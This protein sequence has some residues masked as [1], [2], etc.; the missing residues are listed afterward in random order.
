MLLKYK[1]MGMYT[2]FIIDVKLKENTPIEIIECIYD[3]V[4]DK[5]NETFTYE[6][7]PL[8]NY[9]GSETMRKSFEGLHLKAHGEIKNYWSDIN[10]FIDFIKP[11]VEKGF[12]EDGSFSKSRYEEFEDWDF[13]CA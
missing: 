11:H 13:Y 12:L 9:C 2:E 4:N 6:R 8:L 10:R 7:N 3:M 1:N 5:E